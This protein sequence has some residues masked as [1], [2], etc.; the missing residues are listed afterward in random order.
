[1]HANTEGTVLEIKKKLY[2]KL[3]VKLL[4]NPMSQKLHLVPFDCGRGAGGEGG[5]E[6]EL[7]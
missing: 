4:Y 5:F 7:V 3:H 1:M 2:F 6:P